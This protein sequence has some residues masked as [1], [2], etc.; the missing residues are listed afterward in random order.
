MS[1]NRRHAIG[2]LLRTNWRSSLGAVGGVSALVTVGVAA[3]LSGDDCRSRSLRVCQEVTQ[4]VLALRVCALFIAIPATL[5]LENPMEELATST[6]VSTRARHAVAILPVAVASIIVWASDIVL[7]SSVS[8]A[9]IS[10]L[11]VG[12]LTIEML[13]LL[14]MALL[15]GMPRPRLSTAGAYAPATFVM[16]VA[17]V[18]AVPASRSSLFVESALS[19]TWERAHLLWTG[20]L[21]ACVCLQWLLAMDPW[22]RHALLRR[23]DRSAVSPCEEEDP[24]GPS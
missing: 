22:T 13:A 23:P 18:V 21:V 15:V 14:S 6:P 20:L 11:P 19:P 9:P 12:P 16:L 10:R 3:L 24:I 8:G 2:E 1:L 7:S 5:T 17:A 4:P